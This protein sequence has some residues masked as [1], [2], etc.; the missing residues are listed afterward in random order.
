VAFT[1]NSISTSS[2][3]IATGAEDVA[4]TMSVNTLTDIAQNG[5]DLAGGINVLADN[6]IATCGNAGI[7]IRDDTRVEVR[8]TRIAACQ[9]G[10]NVVGNGATLDATG[11]TVV[12]ASQWGLSAGGHNAVTLR[13]SSIADAGI[14]GVIAGNA[15][16]VGLE[17]ITFRGGV[18]AIVGMRAGTVITVRES[19]FAD[20]QGEVITILPGVHA[21]LF[22]NAIAGPGPGAQRTEGTSDIVVTRG[23][24]GSVHSNR[25]SGFID[26]NPDEPSCGIE[27]EDSGTISIRDNAFPPP[28]NE[29]NVCTETFHATLLVPTS[30]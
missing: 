21:D 7:L 15:S 12:G 5:F 22:R 6:V 8:D 17:R 27:V 10:L 11:L 25:I 4:I 2:F 28:G 19:T 24:S 3:G 18:A 13:D 14:A 23:A 26:S 30:V 1:D 20:H 9:I 29:V 16:Q